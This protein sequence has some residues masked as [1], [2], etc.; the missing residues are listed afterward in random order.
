MLESS[1]Q[2]SRRD[3]L[4]MSAL[5]L[6]AT[7]LPVVPA[8]AKIR[9]LKNGIDISWLPDVEAAGGKFFSASGKQIDPIVLMKQ[10]GITVGRIRVWVNPKDDGAT[11]ARAIMLSK[12]LKAHGLET[13]ID[14][15]FSDTWAD[16]AHQTIPKN[17]STSS[18]TQLKVDVH[19][20]VSQMLN[21]F[22]AAQTQPKW[23]QLGNEVSNGFF[24]PLGKIDSESTEQWR[25]FV[26]LFST[27]SQALHSKLPATKSILHLDCG[28][29]VNKTRWWLQQAQKHGLN[30]YDIL[31]L[32]YYSQWHGSL[33]N[34]QNTLQAALS[35]SQKPILI[36]ET[37]YPWSTR[38]F[39]SDVLDV[40]KSALTGYPLTTTG[41]ANYV[42]RLQTIMRSLPGNNG[43]GIWWWEGLSK[44][45]LNT[46]GNVTWNGGMDNSLLVNPDG[47]PLPSFKALGT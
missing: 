3:F 24:W 36:A 19:D 9:K 26:G 6:G 23:V 34:L 27:A 25:N 46:R 44:Q 4:A 5:S 39:G 30:D 37:A 13:C 16:P 33:Q 18:I 22:I 45:V 2:V 40:T 17:W 32:S 1:M 20:Y 21:E 42:A 43:V 10:M 38:Q 31:G 8:Q 29:D 12:R 7:L 28:G 14:F 41:Q 47:Y 11:L 15:H 35:V